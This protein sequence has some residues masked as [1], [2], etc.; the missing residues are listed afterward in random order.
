MK[1]NNDTRC[2]SCGD[3]WDF[4]EETGSSICGNCNYNS[5]D[6]EVK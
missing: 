6:T 5:E 2:P 3:L 1:N 4:T